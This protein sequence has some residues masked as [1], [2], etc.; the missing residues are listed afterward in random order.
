MMIDELT[1]GEAKQLARMFGAQQEED[2]RLAQD[3]EMVIVVLQRGWVVVGDYSQN[4]SVGRLEDAKVIRVWGTSDGLGELASDGPLS[5]TI[6]DP[7]PPVKFHI[8]EVVMVMEVNEYAW[9][10]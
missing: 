2:C 8:R 1:I 3:G 5:N 4:G 9:G 6:L 10:K 7:C